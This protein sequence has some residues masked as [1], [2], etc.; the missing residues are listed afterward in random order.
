MSETAKPAGLTDEQKRTVVLGATAG[1]LVVVLVVMQVAKNRG[2]GPGESVV[3]DRGA[4][5]RDVA[6]SA[7]PVGSDEKKWQAHY[8]P[9]L[10]ADPFRERTF[11]ARGKGGKGDAGPT[12][13]A[14]VSSASAPAGN[15]LTLTLTAIVRQDKGAYAILESR[16]T[17]RGLFLV[18]GD[19]VGQQVVQISSDTLVL[20]SAIAGVGSGSGVAPVGSGGSGVAPAG[21]DVAPVGTATAAAPPRPGASPTPAPVTVRIGSTLD[22][23][24]EDVKLDTLGSATVG[25]SGTIIPKLS[26]EQKSDVLEKLRAKRKASLGG[27]S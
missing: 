15:T 14:P 11:K 24:P 3:P 1:I 13:P 7:P 18:T 20:A 21:T 19:R 6:V 4:S 27:G 10:D 26:E 9:I 23:R 5:P 22:V 16:G 2:T 25:A 12:D 17:G 8:K